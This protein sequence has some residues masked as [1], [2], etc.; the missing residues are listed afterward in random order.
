MQSWELG[1]I[2]FWS[3]GG[4]THSFLMCCQ[5]A[6]LFEG[7]ELP[8]LELPKAHPPFPSSRHRFDEFLIE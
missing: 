6:A 8:E 7:L 1:V 3:M 5:S 4:G 2:Y